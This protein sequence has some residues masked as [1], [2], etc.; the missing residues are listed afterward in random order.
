MKE[1]ELDSIPNLIVGL[2]ANQTT[3][4]LNRKQKEL[5]KIV[6]TVGES[7]LDTEYSILAC[8]CCEKAWQKIKVKK[9]EYKDVKIECK[10]PDILIKFT[11]PSGSII[12]KK[13]EL[14]SSKTKKIKGSTIGNLNVNQPL[15][16]SLRPRSPKGKYIFRCSLYYQA[17][18]MSDY[19][20]FQDRTPRPDLS[21]DKM[22]G[23]NEDNYQESDS[24]ISIR[25]Y[26]KC[27][28]NRIRNPDKCKHSWQDDLTKIQKDEILKD[29]IKKTSIE[30]F[31]E[32]KLAQGIQDLKI[33]E[34]GG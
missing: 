24:K 28:L 29:F 33:D 1:K 34:E 6:W 21:F 15:I 32:M 7:N 31:K 27:S 19:D 11:L 16:C 10:H 13:I 25:H 3:K 17:M 14:K 22:A 12:D 23:I 26:A 30:N 8:S 20:L 4:I 5:K 2:L 18:G 9:P